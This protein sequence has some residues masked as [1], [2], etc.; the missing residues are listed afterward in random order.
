MYGSRLQYG[1]GTGRVWRLRKSVHGFRKAARA[2]QAKLQEAF[3]SVDFFPLRS[4]TS[5]FRGIIAGSQ[6]YAFAY[7]NGVL[8][9]FWWC[10]RYESRL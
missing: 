9:W 3:N 2:W 10:V 6:L 4:D 1:D 5:L 8:L 7:V